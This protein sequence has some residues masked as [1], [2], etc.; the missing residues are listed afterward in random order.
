MNLFENTLEF[1]KALDQHDDLKSYR[2]QFHFPQHNGAPCIYFCGNSLGL[3]PKRT[4][5]LVNEELNDWAR[6][7]VEGH[8]KAETGWFGY[9]NLLKDSTARLV[10]AMPKEV[11]VMNHLTVNVHLLMVSFYRPTPSRYKIICEGGAFPS[12]RYALQTQVIHHGLNPKDALIELQPR[13]GEETVRTEDILKAIHD[14]GDA[15]A[16]VMFGGV[17]YFTGQVMEF[18]TI[19]KAAHAVG[20]YAGFD[21]AHAAGNIKLKLHDWSVDFAAWCSYKYLNGGPGTVAG[22]F[23]HEKHVENIELPRFGGWW[24][25]DPELRFK[26]PQQFV[27]VKSADAWQLSNAPIL[28]MA[29]LRASMELFDAAGMTQLTAKSY[30]LTSYLLHVV[31][32]V[33]LKAGKEDLIL[34]IT[35]FEEQQQ[36]CQL[37]LQ[38]KENGKAIFD[39]LTAAGVIADWREPDQPGRGSGVIRVA[40][41]PM[42]NSF[43]DVYRFGQLLAK[44]IA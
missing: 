17:H 18:E 4:A 34:V 33:L 31:K 32:D 19:T 6:L 24:G 15:L 39:S 35:P 43:E 41:V 20:A 12:D 21:L 3:Q 38:F 2:E 40:P 16:L 22:V 25:N 37:S 44:A 1:A 27:P 11:V 14:C 8:F 36:G 13:A 26:M 30:T 23:I 9:H 42:Y 28:E 10:G 29:A 7:G 5:E